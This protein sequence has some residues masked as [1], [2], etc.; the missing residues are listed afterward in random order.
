LLERYAA[1]HCEAA[2]TEL[3]SRYV[4]LVYSAALRQVDGDAHL[5]QDVT[6]AVF[7]D[8]ARKAAS[9]RGRTV[10]AGWLYTSTRYAAAKAVRCERRW[11]LREQKANRMQKLLSESASEPDW[12]QLRPVLDAVMHELSEPDRNAVVLRYL[13]G[14]PLAEVGAKLGLTEDAARK[15]VDRALDRLRGLLAKRGVTSTATALVTVLSNQAVTAAPAGLAVAVAG[16]ALASV[17]SG[18]GTT[19]TVFKIMTMTKLRLAVV[20][21]LII[22]GAATPLL[23]QHQAQVQLRRENQAL[24]QQNDQ[25]AERLAPLAAENAR[26]S[27]IVAQVAKASRP[28]ELLR[29][30][31]E[32]GALRRQTNELAELQE[33]LQQENQRLREVSKPEAA[34]AAALHS[35]K[36]GFARNFALALISYAIENQNQFPTN[37]DQVTRF[38]PVVWKHSPVPT[39]DLDGFMK[40]TDQFEIVS[41][42]SFDKLTDPGSVI[43]VRERQAWLLPEGGWAKTYGYA[44]GH[45]ETHTTT[46]GN[47]DRWD[48]QSLGGR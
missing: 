5:A 35:Q 1:S 12:D 13:A 37:F 22:T 45:T 6:Q 16:T 43:V 33:K 39:S 7:I 21:A 28:P 30:R 8:L 34:A 40:A 48:S 15:R 31:G 3:V 26:L 32:I 46:D 47:F 9:M 42:G 11:R 27:N 41:S 4:D 25:M 29:L 20:S 19:L 44:D 17:A 18:T 14:R 2:F 24:R 38:F 36:A 10:L 23:L